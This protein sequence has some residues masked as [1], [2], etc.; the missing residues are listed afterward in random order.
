KGYGEPSLALRRASSVTSASSDDS[1]ESFVSSSSMYDSDGDPL[2]GA[3]KLDKD[4]VERINAL[5]SDPSSVTADSKYMVNTL[6]TVFSSPRAISASFQ[7]EQR[8]RFRSVPMK[9][10]NI[11]VQEA[12]KFAYGWL[13]PDPSFAGP[14]KAFIP[15]TLETFKSA[16]L[17]ALRRIEAKPIFSMA[18]PDTLLSLNSEVYEAMLED[19]CRVLGL[20]FLMLSPSFTSSGE[21]DKNPTVRNPY[22]AERK[23]FVRVAALIG[24]IVLSPQFAHTAKGT[25]PEL[26][27]YTVA[28]ITKRLSWLKRH[29][30]HFFSIVPANV[31]HAWYSVILDYVIQLASQYYSSALSERA[32]ACTVTDLEHPLVPLLEFLRLLY[33]G[34]ETILSGASTRLLPEE[35]ECET[36][37]ACK[38][39]ERDDFASPEFVKCFDIEEEIGRWLR[40]A[41][42][43]SSPEKE[44]GRIDPTV[45]S[46]F[47]TPLIYPFLVPVS[48]KAEMLAVEMHSRLKLRYLSSFHRQTEVTQS[49]R[50]LHVDQF[51]EQ[52]T[53]PST[54]L[55][56]PFFEANQAEM[57]AAMNPYLVLAVRR[58]HIVQDTM[59]LMRNNMHRLRYPFKV[60]FVAGGEDGVDLGGVQKEFFRQLMPRLLSPD[61]GL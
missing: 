24:K 54:D 60:R 1:Q 45:E 46:N 12:L 20:L 15:E 48:V 30:I 56:W 10:L 28:L 22:F 29:W 42:Y 5:F 3:T 58:S 40:H 41:R 44:I 23:L 7:L 11:D 17:I 33:E 35:V 49:Q 13:C 16:T 25:S 2:V 34:N 61:Y 53:L 57:K 4:I 6:R 51:A 55:A 47:F 32:S 14:N 21:G 37:R 39:L 9:T 27:S 19:A 26:P 31:V 43:Q 8:P 52:S 18:V 50:L 59:D 38:V 36:S